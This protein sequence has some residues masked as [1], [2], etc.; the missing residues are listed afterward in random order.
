MIGDRGQPGDLK[1]RLRRAQAIGVSSAAG[2]PLALAL[3]VLDD[4]IRRWD[5]PTTAALSALLV[6]GAAERREAQRYPLLDV[7]AATAALAEETARVARSP[8]ATGTSPAPLA[9]S[10]AAVAALEPE[11]RTALV[12]AWGDDVTMVDPRLGFWVQVAAGPALELAAATVGAPDPQEWR[13]AACPLCGGLP[14]VSVISERPGDLLGGA[15]RS[16]VCGRCTTWWAFSRVTCPSCGEDNPDR[17]GNHLVDGLGWVR[18]DGC[19]TCGGYIKT[20]DLREDASREVV[21]L[22]DDVASL[23]LDVWATSRGLSR[24]V[25][26]LAG[27]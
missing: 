2:E 23:T 10:R 21:P 18:I 11:A 4:Q 27:V 22:V 8:L 25:R 24:P 13:G 19:D 1:G 6:A 12:A 26:S 5:S 20:F 15:P 3:A 14:Q 7:P 17:I 16:L 9:E